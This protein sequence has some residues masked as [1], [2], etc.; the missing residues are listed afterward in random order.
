MEDME[1]MQDMED[2][3]V[4]ENQCCGAGPILTGS[5]SEYFFHRLRLRLQ[6]R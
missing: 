3:E 1:K 5:G 6:L 4:I 2:V